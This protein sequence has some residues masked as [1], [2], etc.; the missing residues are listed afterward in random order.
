[1]IEQ[2]RERYSRLPEE[3]KA[4]RNWCLAGP[5]RAPY[6]V[7]PGEVLLASVRDP[8]TWKTFEETLHDMVATNAPGIGFMLTPEVGLT[9]IDMDVVDEESQRRKGKPI[10]PEKWTTAEDLERYQKII[11]IFNSYTEVS[12]SGKGAHLWLWGRTGAGA[13]RDGVEVYSQE[14]FIVCTGLPF[15]DVPIASNQEMLDLLVEEVRGPNYS[16]PGALVEIEATEADVVIWERAATAANAE[17]FEAL[18]RG[19]WKLT[20]PSQSEA[21]LALMSMF[22]FYTKSNDQCRKLFRATALGSREKATKNDKY[23]NFTL[24][25]IRGR[26]AREAVVDAR[27]EEMARALVRNLQSSSFADVAAAAIA[28]SDTPT[29]DVAGAI[30][31]PPGLVGALAHFIYASSPRPIKEISILTALGFIAGVT[32]RAFN[33]SNSGLN[34]YLIVVA[35][36]GVGKEAIHSGISLICEKLR[37]IS[38][39][40]QAFVDFSE[41]ASGQGLKKACSTQN[42]FL[43]VSGEWGRKLRRIAGEERG[44]GPM[45]TLR[46]EMTNLYQK[47]GRGNLVGGISYSNKEQNLSVM[48]AVAYSMI[49]ETTPG[50]FFESLTPSMMEDGFLSRFIIV[51]YK[52]DRPPLNHQKVLEMSGPLAQGLAGLC[53]QAISNNMKNHS[54]QIATAPEA[55]EMLN[56]FDK[57]CDRRINSTRDESVRQMWNR[58]H[59]KVLRVAGA[60]AAS[61][62]W[63]QPMVTVEHVQWALALIRSDIKVMAERIS[64]GDLGSG[65]DHTRMQK[66]FS[67]VRE[68]FAKAEIS[69][70]YGVADGMREVGLITHR[71]LQMRTSQLT[72]FRNSRAGAKKALDDCIRLMLD[73]GNIQEVNKDTLAEKFAY[74]GRCYRTISIPND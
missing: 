37:E 15:V 44:D 33:I 6:F 56:T 30:D 1:M 7:K 59:L 66:T 68:Y 72:Q 46:T 9:C 63:H 54:E 49:G 3:M 52:G 5:D 64:A 41:M 14:R 2:A 22:A 4:L 23:L 51:E 25:L 17:K 16:G 21:D 62:N 55:A 53:A 50:T 40:A 20:Y 29:V 31:W 36:S 34:M 65:D 58:A 61:D 42:S 47:S 11:G 32:G 10:V 74:F 57:E 69:A 38:P 27:G 12:A 28:V 18:V 26:Q 45:A 70:S 48:S 24:E 39:Q 13:R 73:N 67:L 35:Q 19:D 60:L 8:K 71:Y 43:N